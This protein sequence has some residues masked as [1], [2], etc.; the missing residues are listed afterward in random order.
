MRFPALKVSENGDTQNK[1]GV[2]FVHSSFDAQ[3]RALK[4]VISNAARNRVNQ[5]L[6]SATSRVATI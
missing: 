1:L 2:R 6:V 4:P 5:T 3:N